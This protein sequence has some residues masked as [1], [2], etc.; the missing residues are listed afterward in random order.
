MK[1]WDGHTE[2][3]CVPYAICEQHDQ[4]IKD[5]HKAIHGNGNP[6]EGLLWMT[7]ENTQFIKK[8]QNMFDRLLVY[9]AIAGGSAIISLLFQIFTFMTKHG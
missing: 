8:V 7:K 6:E 5:L 2:R 3:R 4:S 1:D 9:F